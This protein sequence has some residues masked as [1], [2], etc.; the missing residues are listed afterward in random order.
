MKQRLNCHHPGTYMAAFTMY[1][2][3][4]H[5]NVSCRSRIP[6]T[7]KQHWHNSGPAEATW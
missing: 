4:T 1:V 5:G 6:G 7:C 3:K 2:I